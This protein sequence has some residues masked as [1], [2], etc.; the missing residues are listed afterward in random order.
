MLTVHLSG[1]LFR[2]TTGYYGQ[3]SEGKNN[4]V[5]FLLMP[6]VAFGHHS[7]LHTILPKMADLPGKMVALELRPGNRWRS[8]LVKYFLLL[9]RHL[10]V[11]IIFIKQSMAE[12]IG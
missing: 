5:L 8:V 1:L 10:L 3:L 6:T 9:R 12:R 4:S 7:I 2:M 11:P